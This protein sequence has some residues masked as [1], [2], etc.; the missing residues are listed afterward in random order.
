MA[1]GRND[2]CPCHSGK[3]Y[4]HCCARLQ[5]APAPTPAVNAQVQA[6][7]RQTQA[8]FS[9]QQWSL[10][11]Q[12]CRQALAVAPD[13]ADVL[14]ALGV[15]ALQLSQGQTAEEWIARAIQTARTPS[16]F[17]YLNLGMAQHLQGKP[18]EATVSL[19]KALALRPQNAVTHWRL[20]TVLDA[21][22]KLPE[23]IACYQKA[24]A[25]QPD[26]ADA[27]NCL[28]VAQQRQDMVQDAEA[29]YRRALALRPQD[30]QLL[31]NLGAALLTRGAMEDAADC[32]RKA[33]TL[34]PDF[35][36]ALSNLGAAL[37]AMGQAEEAVACQRRVLE[38]L[39]DEPHYFSNVLF[40]LQYLPHLSARELL[41]EHRK[42]AARFEAHHKPLWP[43]HGNERSPHR[44]LR[45]GYVS[46]DFRDHVLASFFE[47]V[48]A[49]HDESRIETFCYY[50]NTVIDTV[51]GRLRAL[52]D[53]WLPCQGM[54]DAEL[55]AQIGADGIDILVDLGG[56]TALNRL[57]VFARK[58]APVQVTWLGYP[59]TTGLDAVDYRLSDAHLDPENSVASC[60]SEAVMHL[61]SWAV[62]SPDPASPPINDL[63]ALASGH[64]TL[65]CLNNLAKVSVE[66]IELWAQILN[67]LP[68]AR[69]LVCNA[70]EPAVQTRL[71]R[72]FAAAGL[73]ADRLQMHGKM[74]LQDYLALHHRIDLALDP[75][76]F[77]GGATTYHALWMGVPVLT[78]SGKTT[79]SRQ[80]AAIMQGA[81]L[82]QFVCHTQ[83]EY[84][85]KAVALAANLPELQAVRQS[86]RARMTAGISPQQLT[87]ALEQAF[88][89]M[90]QRWCLSGGT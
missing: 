9:A 43:A 80:G 20:G 47:P 55:A 41:D 74:S 67:A 42:F 88:H 12:C 56:H 13:N 85:A 59:G 50:N 32:L 23:A 6:L 36:M 28:G 58:P 48:L 54:N 49:H 37:F 35:V 24:V 1:V 31:C 60:L 2:P 33:L 29:S 61:P 64:L 51:T 63:P 52:A 68:G 66:V 76:P 7:L 62:F 77:T 38:L 18:A 82:P 34:Q 22:G 17:M 11:E 14:V 26:H 40:G 5:P 8:F 90:W 72:Q 16:D 39:P 81:G 10:A 73:S 53:H 89:T 27:W 69:L 71:Q 25:L 83:D 70:G 46:A 57:P 19:R 86:L 65:A 78:L 84:L 3:K 44:R 4:K 45:V 79:V 21:Q 87:T 30:T 75:F 15:I